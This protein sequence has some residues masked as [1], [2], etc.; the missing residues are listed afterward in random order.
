MRGFD[1]TS[2]NAIANAAQVSKATVYAYFNGKYDILLA[3]LEEM[4]A[5][6]PGPRELVLNREGS[7]SDSLRG[8]ARDVCELLTGPM[9]KSMYRMV[10]LS[11]SLNAHITEQFAAEIFDRYAR[12]IEAF[13][14]IEVSAGRLVITDVPCAS[15]QFLGLAIGRPILHTVLT[16][17]HW[18][19]VQSLDAHIE[20][21]VTFFLT[22]YA[23]GGYLPP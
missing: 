2:V 14:Y 16:G 1:G 17:N 12:A 8:I 21:A 20:V 15:A 6:L 9:M 4:L 22:T 11:T 13:L 18:P 5:A 3:A 19:S 23:P 10:V 7:L